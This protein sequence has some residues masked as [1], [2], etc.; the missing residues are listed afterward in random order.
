MIIEQERCKKG[1]GSIFLK[2]C[3]DPW[4]VEIIVHIPIG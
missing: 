3:E 2:D 4:S 1:D